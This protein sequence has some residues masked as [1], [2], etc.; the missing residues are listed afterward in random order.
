MEHVQQ[1]VSASGCFGPGRLL[2]LART[3]CGRPGQEKKPPVEIPPNEPKKPPVE[4]P[5]EPPEPTPPP[6]R[7]PVKEP[8]DKPRKPPVREPPPEDPNRRPP[9]KTPIRFAA[10]GWLLP[11]GVRLRPRRCGRKTADAATRTRAPAPAGPRPP[12]RC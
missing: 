11:G 1:V 3:F 10:A 2:E 7:P 8:P 6:K 5:G 12:K 9:G 4:E